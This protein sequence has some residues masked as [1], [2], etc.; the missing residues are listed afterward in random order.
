MVSI[1]FY[2]IITNEKIETPEN[3]SLELHSN[4][5]MIE[6]YSKDTTETNREYYNQEFKNIYIGK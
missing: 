2:N 4:Y 1:I 3:T 5:F 6:K